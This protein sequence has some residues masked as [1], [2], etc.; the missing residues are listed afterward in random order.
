MKKLESSPGCDGHGSQSKRS[1]HPDDDDEPWA[2]ILFV[3]LW[4]YGGQS[5]SIH[6]FD[7]NIS[8]VIVAV[9]PARSSRNTSK[10]PLCQV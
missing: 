7:D 8:K 6:C 3:Y 9:V 1:K 4:R 5:R 2:S 10:R